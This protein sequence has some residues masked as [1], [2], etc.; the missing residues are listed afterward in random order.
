MIVVINGKEYI[1]ISEFAELIRH[2]VQSVRYLCERGGRRPLRYIRDGS[3]ILIE[4][5]ELT[6]YPFLSGGRNL[7]NQIYHYRLTEDGYERYLCHSCTFGEDIERCEE[8][9]R[10]YNVV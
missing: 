2:S 8:A 6:E 10:L 1:H 7:S 9:K 5:R 3:R 4:V